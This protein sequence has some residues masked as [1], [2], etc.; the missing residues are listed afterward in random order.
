MSRNTA[1]TAVLL[2]GLAG[3]MVT[4]GWLFAT[5]ASLGVIAGVRAVTVAAS[6]GANRRDRM[7]EAV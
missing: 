2:A 1:M 7:R 3:F 6:L 5:G 4:I